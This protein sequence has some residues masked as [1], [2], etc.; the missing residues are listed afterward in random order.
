MA[1][2]W[3]IWPKVKS[4]FSAK[5]N[6]FGRYRYPHLEDKNWVNLE[7]HEVEQPQSSSPGEK[8]DAF[9][10]YPDHLESENPLENREASL[11]AASSSP[12][13]EPQS[14]PR[15]QKI[16]RGLLFALAFLMPLWFLPF[17]APG[18]ILILSKQLLLF[19]LTAAATVIW[20]TM[21]I[22]QGGVAFRQ[23]GWEWGLLAVWVASLL[24]AIFSPRPYLSFTSSSGLITL[25][26]LMAFFLVGSNF[27]EKKDLI[28]MINY[29]VLGSSL[30]ALLGMLIIL[31]IPVTQ[32]L[33][34]LFPTNIV[35]SDQFNTV[36]SVNSLAALAVIGLVLVFSKSL[37]NFK[38]II[39]NNENNLPESRSW[40][41]IFW[42][43][44]LIFAW[45]ILVLNW[46][47]FYTALIVGLIGLSFGMVAAANRKA[48]ET[49]ST[50]APHLIIPMFVIILS[51]LL[52]LGNRFLNFNISP[53]VLGN[54]TLPLEVSL[55]QQTS[56]SIAKSVLQTRPF[57]GI[58]QENFVSAYEQ[59]KPGAIN[60]TLFW[61]SRF[62][63]SNSEMF[64][65][66]TEGGVVLLSS[67]AVLLFYV[68]YSLVKNLKRRSEKDLTWFCA[69]AFLAVLTFFFLYPFNP[70]LLF[71]FWFLLALIARGQSEENL[72]L[73]KVKMD[74]HSISSVLVSLV[75][76]LVLVGEFAGGYLLWQK[77]FGQ[78]IFAKAA[79]INIAQAE[80][81]DRVNN[82]LTRAVNTSNDDVYLSNLASSLLRKI[83]LE[84]N[85]RTDDPNVVQTRLQNLINQVVR[86]TGQMIQ[87]DGNNAANWFNAGF[88]YENL[89]T[90][91]G[92]ADEAALSAYQEYAKRAPNN[93]EIYVRL[94]RI[95]LSRAERNSR[96]LVD[97]KQ[98][99]LDITNEKGV[100]EKIISDYQS[101]EK[102]F[103]KAV[104]QK[105][106]LATALYNLGIIYERQNQLGSAIKQLEQVR[107]IETNNPGLSF[108][109]GLL[110]YRAGE[111][112]KA[113]TEMA[114][115][116]ALFSDYA[117]AR[118]Y[119]AL[120]LEEQGRIDL[121]IG[122]LKAILTQ[123]VN[124][125]NQIL[126]DKLAALEAGQR[127]IP[128]AT[129]TNKEPLQS[130]PPSQ[131]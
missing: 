37:G 81:L 43:A 29:F 66:L 51:L 64:D 25:S 91:L 60:R 22:K 68:F 96:A 42:A 12:S 34:W 121:A 72:P 126:L 21:I 41:G 70:L 104:E 46:W 122:Q 82:L 55:S 86:V 78:V 53:I 32:V 31:G 40:T 113:L 110:Y 23:S 88:V 77:Y 13:W 35:V 92:G 127:E 69:P 36:G 7:S 129:V 85:N 63:N 118:W 57:L 3:N 1:W 107:I 38:E 2:N 83:S 105:P 14:V 26:S 75:L 10:T 116:V 128:P 19:G 98:K 8:V 15:L 4:R 130:R 33:N 103:K 120:M 67:L 79:R 59:F 101:A 80:D 93:P 16:G 90:V 119:L 123:E 45:W 48:R 62:T 131:R 39:K 73:L 112:N 20:V 117:N 74:N 56:W 17:A 84:I 125:D 94:G 61:N 50:K 89:I 52:I 109:L 58:G 108:E 71:T 76:A 95:Y 65:W 30:A 28:K 124:K 100:L 44:A 114:R 18:D 27:W 54:K 9:S 6:L 99:K 5:K 87:Q 49:T 47:V 106:D 111:K 11:L 115:A 102:S 24:A 97:A